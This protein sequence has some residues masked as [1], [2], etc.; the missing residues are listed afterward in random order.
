MKDTD[1]KLSTLDAPPPPSRH[2]Q[3]EA[4]EL[5][6]A[7][8]ERLKSALEL[9]E[10]GMADLELKRMLVRRVCRMYRTAEGQLISKL[11]E[12]IPP[13]AAEQWGGLQDVEELIA[14]ARAAAS[15]FAKSDDDEHLGS[16]KSVAKFRKP[17]AFG[18]SSSEGA[19]AV[20]FGSSQALLGDVDY[21]EGDAKGLLKRLKKSA[22]SAKSLSGAPGDFRK[23][24]ERARAHDHT[25]TAIDLAN[26]ADFAALDPGHKAE[27][28]GDLAGA[29]HSAALAEVH[30]DGVGLDLSIAEPLGRLLRAPGLR[31]LTITANRLN[32]AALQRLALSMHAHTGLVE[33]AVGEQHGTALSTHAIREL[34][35]AAET[36]ATLSKLRLGTIHDDLQRRRHISLETRHV[37]AMRRIHHEE[38]LSHSDGAADD[39]GALGFLGGFFA[40]KKRAQAD[41]DDAARRAAEEAAKLDT[42]W[43]R[44]AARIAATKET[45]LG[46]PRNPGD[47]GDDLAA[48]EMAG[49]TNAG[50]GAP[51]P[52]VP[53]RDPATHYILTGSAEWRGATKAE[54]RVV[55]E[56]FATNT[57]F[58]TVCMSDSA[59]DDDLARSWAAVLAQPSCPIA[60]L[61]LE[62]NPMSSAGIE[63]IASALASNTSL[64]DLRLRNLHGK[65]SKQAEEA[66]GHALEHHTRLTKLY[67]D[68]RSF[69]AQ[70]LMTRYLTRNEMARRAAKGWD[71]AHNPH[72]AAPAAGGL[73]DPKWKPP[74]E[75]NRVGAKVTN[76]GLGKHVTLA[77][78]MWE[79]FVGRP[80]VFDPNAL[81]E[82]DM[83]APERTSH[84]SLPYVSLG[85]L[86]KGVEQKAKEMREARADGEAAGATAA[87]EAEEEEPT[88]PKKKSSKVNP[89]ANEAAEYGDAHHD[90]TVAAV[91]ALEERRSLHEEDDRKAHEWH[92]KLEWMLEESGELLPATSRAATAGG[93][94][95]AGGW[96]DFLRV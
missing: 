22:K 79:G 37:E 65:V 11:K 84:A 38:R 33:L 53:W 10:P 55:I 26:R 47:D 15:A 35:D 5:P 87:V 36:I 82:V 76:S 34:L 9:L 83:D 29:A 80:T 41:D 4:A 40:K 93:A 6:A 51:P 60:S 25:L 45:T 94:Q 68:L 54:R 44:E 13:D 1:A 85:D 19:Q 8:F 52:R 96:G 70:D 18:S 62:S 95:K 64:I 66:L 42:L 73:W 50:G 3:P 92:M 23:L 43:T 56:A 7:A 57:K 20:S 89:V 78:E 2:P 75:K 30:L 32:E 46:R 17:A 12:F 27:A 61:T 74:A 88:K 77:K 31:V 67:V 39:S 71:A 28:V 81:P 90:E 48:E 59:I 63:A 86:T 14:S 91:A 69:K 49:S 24:L 58:T 21:S 72:A 16:I